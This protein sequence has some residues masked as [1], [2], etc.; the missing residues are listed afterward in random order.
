MTTR[1]Q[2]WKQILQLQYSSGRD[3]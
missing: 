1:K 2:D 3:S